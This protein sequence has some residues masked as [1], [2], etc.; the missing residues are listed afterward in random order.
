MSPLAPVSTPLPAAH[1]PSDGDLIRYTI[2][3]GFL[4]AGKTTL[5]AGML[6]EATERLA[7]IVNDLGELGL[8]REI[9]SRAT[10]TDQGVET[11]EL[12]GGCVCCRAGSSLALTLRDLCRRENP[13]EHVVLECSGVADPTRV[14]RYGSRRVLREPVTVVVVDATDIGRRLTD[15]DWGAL[16]RAQVSAADVLVVSK[17]DLPEGR[18]GDPTVPSPWEGL[19]GPGTPVFTGHPDQ[20]GRTLLGEHSWGSGT[21]GGPQGGPDGVPAPRFEVVARPMPDALDP[22][23]LSRLLEGIAG[24]VRAKGVVRTGEGTVVAQWSAGRLEVTPWKGDEVPGFGLT[25][26]TGPN[27]TVPGPPR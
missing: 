7:V 20:V 27:P 8:D 17:R 11:V 19:V 14:A 4:G 3:A 10:R 2:V 6:R 1:R 25:L 18:G 26:I 24:L 15:P 23:D 13:P 12:D 9:L 5:I 16:A 22:V 21:G